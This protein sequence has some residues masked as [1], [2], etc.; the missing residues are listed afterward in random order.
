MFPLS[1]L[2]QRLHSLTLSL[3]P[4]QGLDIVRRDW[5]PLS[6]EL[7]QKCLDA[8]LSGKAAEEV[9]ETIHETLRVARTALDSGYILDK[10]V[11][12][13]QLTKSPEDYPDAANQAHVQVG[14]LS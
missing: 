10:L 1:S 4:L 6:K 14:C 2:K 11:I 9:V 3:S 13:K 8:I 7:G 5:C 12:T